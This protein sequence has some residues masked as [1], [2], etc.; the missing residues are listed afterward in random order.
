ML[1][2]SIKGRLFLEETRFRS[3][4]NMPIHSIRSSNTLSLR[5]GK[6]N[7]VLGFS[8]NRMWLVSRFFIFLYYD[9]ITKHGRSEYQRLPPLDYVCSRGS[10][11][12][13][14]GQ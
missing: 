6:P 14:A 12:L 8:A 1:H 9:I 11:V 10:V 7:C 13:G 5:S 3:R 2:R 4:F